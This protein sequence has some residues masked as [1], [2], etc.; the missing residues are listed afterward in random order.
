METEHHLPTGTNDVGLI[1]FLKEYNSIAVSVCYI[2]SIHTTLLH[3]TDLTGWGTK[4]S[5]RVDF[6]LTY[7]SCMNCMAV[8]VAESEVRKYGSTYGRINTEVRN[9]VLALPYQ[10]ACYSTTPPAAPVSIAC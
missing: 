3:W 4:M 1:L 8:C 10:V 6:L 7:L 2:Q 5:S 9:E